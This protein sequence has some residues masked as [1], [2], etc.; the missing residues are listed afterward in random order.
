MTTPRPIIF[1]KPDHHYASYEDFWRL[2]EVS[3]FPVIP[4]ADVDLTKDVDYIFTPWNG[5]V[6]EAL[7]QMWMK[8]EGKVRARIVWWNLER[9]LADASEEERKDRLDKTAVQVDMIWVSD[10][11]YATLDDRFRHVILGG[12]PGFADLRSVLFRA[13]EWQATL[14]AYVWGRRQMIVDDLTRH[15]VTLAPGAWTQENRAWVLGGTRLMVNTHQ[16]DAARTIA[17]IR[18]A[19]AASYGMGLISEPIDD[20]FPLVRGVHYVEC[21][22]ENLGR[23][24]VPGGGDPANFTAPEL[25]DLL[26][27]KHRFDLE[28]RRALEAPQ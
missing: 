14:Y 27:D 7:P 22:T 18:F 6:A 9:D 26:V 11:A 15:G 17:P 13:K 28:V 23:L 10:R 16:Y 12:H 2:V 1:A 8:A 25:F 19:V 20:P 21:P 4:F 3:G 24:L 5:Q